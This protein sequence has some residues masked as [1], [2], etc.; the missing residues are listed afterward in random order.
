M[1]WQNLICNDPKVLYG[2]P[3]ISGT[4][5]PVDLVLEKLA[6]GETFDEILESYPNISKEQIK[7][8][9]A[10]ATEMLRN[11]TNLPLVS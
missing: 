5:I 3:V 7:A 9:L 6:H 1:C 8:C 2:K 4:R 10:Y 11:E